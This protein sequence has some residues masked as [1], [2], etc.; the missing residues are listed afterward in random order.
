MTDGATQSGPLDRA[1][2]FYVA[3]HRGMVGGAL[4]RALAARGHSNVVTAARAEVDLTDRGAVDAFFARTRPAYVA[5]AAA[6]VGG[7]LAN[8]RLGGDFIR[9]NLLIQTHVID[10]AQRHG[11]R[12]FVFLGSSCIYPRDAAQPIRED[13]L[14]TGPLE[15]TNRAYAVAK[16]AGSAMC[17]AYR[18]Q[19][20][21]D[22][23]T[24]MPCNVY[25]VGDNFDP[26]G[27]HVIAGLMRR[28]HA[29]KTAGAA[30]VTAWG[31]GAPLREFIEADDLGDAIL[32]L[33]EHYGEGG[34]IN[35]GSGR[36]ISIRDLTGLVA[37]TVGYAGRIIWDASKPDG[38]PRKLMDSG[39]LA[40]LGWRPR[41]G[42]RAGL[43][44]MYAWFLEERVPPMTA[45]GQDIRC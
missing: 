1:A 29:A 28:F 6:K 41:T 40:A 31:T 21:F 20:G 37:E 42:F 35:A 27:S 45:A 15:E 12:R 44:K 9:E 25:G 26:E 22:A 33:M 18:R 19:H 30:E 39:R 11:V 10:A 43:A 32:F 3:G 23:F 17:D 13:A 14:M 16:I 36:E 8:D 24:V 2:P 34:L 5:L 4:M 38:T 7:I